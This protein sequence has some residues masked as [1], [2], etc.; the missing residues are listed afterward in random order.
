MLI[1][2]EKISL[3]RRPQIFNDHTAVDAALA[4]QHDR[5]DRWVEYI[6]DDLASAIRKIGGR[7]PS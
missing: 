2:T 4:E 3:T 1:I 6:M 7:K 5:Q